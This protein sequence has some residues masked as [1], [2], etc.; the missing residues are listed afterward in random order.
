LGSKTHGS[1]GSGETPAMKN[2]AFSSNGVIKPWVNG[3]AS[4]LVECYFSRSLV[5]TPTNFSPVIAR[6][7]R[8]K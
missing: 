8:H 6:C 1:D 4:M 3:D 7:N 5:V 2:L